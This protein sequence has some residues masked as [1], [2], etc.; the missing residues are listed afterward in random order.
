MDTMIT[1]RRPTLECPHSHGFSKPWAF[2]DQIKGSL[3]RPDKDSSM[4][5]EF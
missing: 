5:R 4:R 3:F 1:A 2:L